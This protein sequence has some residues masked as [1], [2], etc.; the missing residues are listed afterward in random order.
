MK[1]TEQTEQ[2]EKTKQPEQAKQPGQPEQPE[3]AKQPEQP[4]QAKQPEQP[5]QSEKSMSDVLAIM[6]EKYES[7]IKEVE[8]RLNAAIKDRDEV[9]KQLLSG[10]NAAENK[11]SV[12]EKIN[13]RRKN[14]KIW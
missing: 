12:F 10:E 3:Q 5:E 1:Q 4:E 11:M 13:E 7:Q 6:K 2:T 14:K 8:D 9:I